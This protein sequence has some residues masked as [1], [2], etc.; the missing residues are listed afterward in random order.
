MTYAVFVLVGVGAVIVTTAE[1]DT[2]EKTV[3]AG[4]VTVRVT[5][6]IAGRC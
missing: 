2:P 6:V 4:G 5:V 1:V 3:T